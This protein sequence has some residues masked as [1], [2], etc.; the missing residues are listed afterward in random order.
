MQLICNTK[1]YLKNKEIT[2]K[3]KKLQYCHTDLEQCMRTQGKPNSATVRGTG[4]KEFM[5]DPVG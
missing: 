2:R 4:R 5:M 1:P 3:P